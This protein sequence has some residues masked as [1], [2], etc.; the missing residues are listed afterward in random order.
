MLPLSLCIRNITSISVPR[1]DNFFHLG[2]FPGQ[3][4]SDIPWKIRPRVIVILVS[5]GCSRPVDRVR[6]YFSAGPS[7]VESKYRIVNCANYRI[8]IV[9]HLQYLLLDRFFF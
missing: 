2:S 1:V 7:G 9:S 8:S 3:S 5:L 4:S 6:P